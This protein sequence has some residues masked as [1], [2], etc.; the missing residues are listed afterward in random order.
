MMSTFW[1]LCALT[2]SFS[3]ISAQE[4]GLLMETLNI[5]E[6]KHVVLVVPRSQ[7]NTSSLLKSIYSQGMTAEMLLEDNIPPDIDEFSYMCTYRNITK[8][9]RNPDGSC[10]EKEDEILE[11]KEYG[12]GKMRFFHLYDRLPL[13]RPDVVVLVHGPNIWAMNTA[14]TL[15]CD[16]IFGSWDTLLLYPTVGAVSGSLLAPHVFLGTRVAVIQDQTIQAFMLD[17]QGFLKFKTVGYWRQSEAAVSLTE[18]LLPPLRM[19]EGVNLTAITYENHNL[20]SGRYIHKTGETLGGTLGKMAEVVMWSLKAN[21]YMVWTPPILQRADNCSWIGPFGNMERWENDLDIGPV[22]LN[23]ERTSAGDFTTFIYLAP[24]HYIIR[25][26]K[27]VTDIL[28]VVKIYTPE[29]WATIVASV[30][31]VALAF[32]LMWEPPVGLPTTRSR[33]HATALAFRAIV[34][35]GYDHKPKSNSGMLFGGI[36]YLTVVVIDYT[37][38]GLMTA[39]LSTPRFEVMPEKIE[40]FLTLGF[41][42]WI[43]KDFSKYHEMK[44]SPSPVIQQLFREAEIDPRD[45]LIPPPEVV[46]RSLEEKITIMG[47]WPEGALNAYIDYDS[48]IYGNRGVCMLQKV[49]EPLH[50]DVRAW[51]IPKNSPLLEII[52]N[53]MRWMVDTGLMWKYYLEAEEPQCLPPPSK[54]PGPQP[55]SIKQLGAAFIILMSGCTAAMLS[56]IVEHL[57]GCINA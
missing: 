4:T 54:P 11:F 36:F 47:I 20:I 37:Y 23:R 22:P 41:Q 9:I 14:A 24:A 49:K 45:D 8:K 1:I 48:K 32:W 18:P 13:N 51:V 10:M 31:V 55:F 17:S 42:V 21:L 5:L 19:L 12:V 25:F 16:H 28:L 2:A 40:D 26:P 44:G 39:V 7:E 30:F 6:T 27:P 52:N 46:Q 33:K 35:Q 38:N 56:F 15:I 50:S 29:V 3:L 53:R 43:Q 57:L 34:Y